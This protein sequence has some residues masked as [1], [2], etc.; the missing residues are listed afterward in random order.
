AAELEIQKS[1][2][3]NAGR[4]APDVE[5]YEHVYGKPL[6]ELRVL[7]HAE[8]EGHLGDR[9]SQSEVQAFTYWLSKYRLRTGE[10]ARVASDTRKALALL[11][12]LE[13]GRRA[14][15]ASASSA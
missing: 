15:A 3:A 6:E 8:S 14:P 13:A 11:S 10:P 1:G 7:Y 2:L 9:A 5:A 12:R 4:P